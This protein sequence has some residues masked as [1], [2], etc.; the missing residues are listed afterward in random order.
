VLPIPLERQRKWCKPGITK[1]QIKKKERKNDLVYT[2]HDFG[3]DERGSIL[4]REFGWTR[5]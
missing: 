3:D 2:R 4:F 5:E 1:E